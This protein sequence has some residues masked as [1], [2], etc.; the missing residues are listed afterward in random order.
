MQTGP[1]PLLDGR[2]LSQIQTEA[3]SRRF[4]LRLRTNT[5]MSFELVQLRPANPTEPHEEYDENLH[6]VNA[7]VMD[8]CIALGDANAFEF[9]VSGFGDERWPVDVATDLA[10]VLQQ[11]PGALTACAKGEPFD[12]DLFEQG[13]ERRLEFVPRGESYEV[14]CSSRTDWYPAPEVERIDAKAVFAM[15]HRLKRTFCD[16][17]EKLLP[18]TSAHPWF[19]QYVHETAL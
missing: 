19:Q 5:T 11:L 17:C 9:R 2:E 14:R 15:L 10:T 8:M 6:D 4:R 12:L 7:I 13:I 1:L 3:S 16:M 18:E